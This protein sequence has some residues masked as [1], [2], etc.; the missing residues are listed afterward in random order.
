[1]ISHIQV[2]GVILFSPA[3]SQELQDAHAGGRGTVGPGSLHHHH[4]TQDPGPHA[5]P[6]L[7]ADGRWRRRIQ[8]LGDREPHPSRLT[9]APGASLG[10]CM[11]HL[12]H[13]VIW[14][15]SHP[16][17]CL[18][19]AAQF[20]INPSLAAAL[21]SPPLK[22]LDTLHLQIMSHVFRGVREVRFEL[23]CCDLFLRLFSPHSPNIITQSS[24]GSFSTGGTVRRRRM[25]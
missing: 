13:H 25:F 21:I 4:H 18:P 5:V 19:S 3:C 17:F 6:Q 7:R 2:S 22:S 10:S 23:G 24:G 20:L 9:Q 14:G 8:R 1:M 12:R 15:F 16:R 11:T